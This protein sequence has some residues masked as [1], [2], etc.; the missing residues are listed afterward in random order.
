M[1]TILP[2]HTRCRFSSDLECRSQI[3]C[4]Q[5]AENTGHKKSP[6]IRHLGTIAQLY[7]AESLQLRHVSTIGKN[8]LNTNISSTRSYNMLNFRPLMAEIVSGVWGTPAAKFN[9]F[10]VL[11]SLLQ[12][13]RSPEANQTLYDVG[14]LLGCYA[15]YIYIFGGSWPLTK[16]CQ[17]KN[18]VT[19]KS[20]VCY[21]I[22]TALQQR[23]HTRN[24]ITELS[25]RAPPIFGWAAITLGIG[26]HSSFYSILHETRGCSLLTP[27][28][29]LVAISKGMQGLKLCSSILSAGFVMGLESITPGHIA[30]P[31]YWR[32]QKHLGGRM[33][34]PTYSSHGFWYS[35]PG[36]LTVYLLLVFLACKT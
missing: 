17:V 21:R 9:G 6:K 7:L 13:H 24:G 20:C 26:P 35:D 25:Q 1:S 27:L 31:S 12:R 22:G 32:L 19:S 36:I 29:T 34:T 4:R 18:Y 2:F 15:I 11:A 33:W 8:L 3:R 5:L 30:D 28:R 10:R 23:R 16:F 14:R